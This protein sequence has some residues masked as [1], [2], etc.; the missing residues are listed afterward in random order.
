[1]EGCYKDWVQCGD[2]QDKSREQQLLQLSRFCETLWLKRQ[3]TDVEVHVEAKIFQAHKLILT[4][5]SPYFHKLLISTKPEML[6]VRAVTFILFLFEIISLALIC[7][8]A[9]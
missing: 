3:M 6:K 4:C 1:M 5:H 9:T 7:E 2:F 8:N